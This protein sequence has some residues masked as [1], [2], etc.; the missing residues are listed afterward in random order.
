[1][2]RPPRLA[3]AAAQ[4][5]TAAAALRRRGTTLLELMVVMSV[6][7]VAVSIFYQMV[8]ST[9]RLR[10]LNH[11]NAVAIEAARK[12]IE[13]MRNEAFADVWELY[14]A[15]ASDDPGGPGTAP[16]N[17][18]EVEGLI[19][20]PS[21]ADGCVGEIMLP[22]SWVEVSSGT[23]GT[24]SG[25]QIGS[26]GG[27][28]TGGVTA[29]SISEWQLREDFVDDE[30]GMPR[31]LNGDSVVDDEDHGGDYLILPVRVRLRWDGVFGERTMDVFT[32]IGEFRRS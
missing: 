23:G 26:I 2:T 21:A 17:R 18:F 7:L 12:A 32:M 20:L 3:R 25:P 22:A 11:E 14:N 24:G 6:M 31:D 28:S 1:M 29:V 4:R 27:G 19:P 16:G 8:V 30:L 15:D 13:R 10:V 5:P 9:K